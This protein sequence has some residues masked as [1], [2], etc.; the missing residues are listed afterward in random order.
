MAG[1]QKYAN[2]RDP[3]EVFASPSAEERRTLTWKIGYVVGQL[4]TALFALLVILVVF[5]LPY[6]LMS[7][8]IRFVKGLLG[9]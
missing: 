5:G 1:S 9:W 8:G 3:S 4:L 7:G 6:L 2:D